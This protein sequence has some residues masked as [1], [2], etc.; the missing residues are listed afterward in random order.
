MQPPKSIS[1]ERLDDEKWS[2]RYREYDLVKE[3]VIALV[4]VSLLTGVLALVFSSPDVKQVTIAS[5]STAAPNDFVTTA[6]TELDGTSGTA[7]YGAPYTHTAGAAQKL[8]PVS[9]QHLAGVTHPIDTVN[10]FVVNP[11]ERVPAD[12]GLSAAL[13]QWRAAT[14]AQRQNW[15][16]AYDTALQ[17]APDTNPAKV[18]AGAYGPVPTMLNRLLRLAQSGGLDGSLLLQGQFFQTD[19]TKPLLFIADGTF[20]EDQADAQHLG[21]EQWGMMNETGS[22]P[23][24]AW[25]WLYTFWYQ[26]KPFSTSDN[27]DALVFAVMGL[28]SLGLICIPFIPGVRSIPRW[29]PVHRLIWRDY[30]AHQGGE[31]QQDPAHST[32][33]R[34]PA[35]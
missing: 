28:L 33:E 10:D 17:K 9:L 21:G 18:A 34:H 30:Y 4:V 25:L 14:A 8:G 12:A 32:S 24:Q 20:L 29:I 35:T 22:Y 15:A 3:F 16:S 13:G 6:A 31:G 1:V 19:Y 7:T 23:G 5:W 2:G 26:V 27:A 11:L